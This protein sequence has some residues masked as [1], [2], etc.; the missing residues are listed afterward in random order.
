MR[1]E[2]G[3]AASNEPIIKAMRRCLQTAYIRWVALAVALLAGMLPERARAWAEFWWFMT[4]AG[5]WIYRVYSLKASPRL[6][7]LPEPRSYLKRLLRVC[8]QGFCLCVAFYLYLASAYPPLRGLPEMLVLIG[9]AS[10]LLALGYFNLLKQKLKIQG[11]FTLP[12]ALTLLVSIQLS[13]LWLHAI[14]NRQMLI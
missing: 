10:L 12:L 1:T 14:W 13:L 3:A 8:L 4:L 9:I 7:D 6:G 11:Y 2:S 5:L